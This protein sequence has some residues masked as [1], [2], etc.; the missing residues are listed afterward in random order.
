MEVDDDRD[1][2]GV[3]VGEVGVGRLA[4]IVPGEASATGDDA[5]GKSDFVAEDDIAE[6]IEDVGAPVAHFAVAGVPIPMPVVVEFF[7]VDGL[8]LCWAKPEVVVHCGR[9][10]EG[11]REFA[12][13]GAHA[14]V[15]AADV[16]DFAHGAGIE[17]GFDFVLE[18]IAA[19]LGA[20]LD[21]AVVL[22]CGFDEFAA[23]P[24]VVGDGFFHIDILTGLHGPD[25]GEDVPVIAGG[26]DDGIDGFVI[27]DLAE[28][29]GGL[30]VW[31]DLF[32]F[33]QGG[34]VGVAQVR[35]F[36][37]GDLGHAAGIAEALAAQ[38]DGGDADGVI[39][40]EH[41]AG[42]EGRESEGGLRD[43]GTAGSHG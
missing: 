40:A 17:E 10:R 28:V 27:H 21:D 19:L 26:D 20:A 4:G 1:A 12:D 7:A 35:D 23:F 43:E 31:E 36:H 38:A 37:A 39:G 8:V 18:G 16:F 9:R 22:A 24:D 11:L 29:L 34:G 15:I 6:V 42:G 33:V 25:G 32:G 30:G 13:G 2:A 5:L 41:A 14:V 3:H